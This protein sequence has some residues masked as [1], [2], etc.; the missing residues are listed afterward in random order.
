MMTVGFLQQVWHGRDEMWNVK[1][2]VRLNTSR[3]VE[4]DIAKSLIHLDKREG[5]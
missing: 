3:V 4:K 1:S 5:S 2:L